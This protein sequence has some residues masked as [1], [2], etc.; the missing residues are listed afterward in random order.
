MSTTLSA[1]DRRAELAW[2]RDVVLA[3]DK[4]L[5]RGV[6][7]ITMMAGRWEELGCPT[8]L[9]FPSGA[10]VAITPTGRTPGR[11]YWYYRRKAFVPLA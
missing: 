1:A 6:R 7:H 9:R 10:I 8:V 3:D 4:A 11:F 5:R 2:M